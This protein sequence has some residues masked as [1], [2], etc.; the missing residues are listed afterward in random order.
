MNLRLCYRL[1]AMLS[2]KTGVLPLALLLA[3]LCP[4]QDQP[5]AEHDVQPATLVH[6]VSPDYPTSRKKEGLQ[7]IVHLRITIA[8]DG[9]VRE[10]NIVD[11]DS[12]LAKS[13]EKAVKQWRYKPALKDG[14]PVEVQ[15]TVAVAFALKPAQ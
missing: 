13:A 7:G 6:R 12:R 3:T 14:E 4:G 2:I 1:T 11:G 9:S 15:A 8:K 10:V 5:K